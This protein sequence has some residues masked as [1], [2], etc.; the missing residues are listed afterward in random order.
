MLTILCISGNLRYCR[1]DCGL[2][3]SQNLPVAH[4][5][6]WRYVRSHFNFPTYPPHSSTNIWEPVM[7]AT[8]NSQARAA[9]LR[10]V[11][12]NVRPPVPDKSS[13]SAIYTHWRQFYPKYD[14]LRHSE[15]WPSVL[16]F[17]AAFIPA[18]SLP[19]H[20]SIR[21]IALSCSFWHDYDLY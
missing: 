17:H 7:S 5:A 21:G 10:Q 4:T 1:S 12:Q 11:L 19:S 15:R 9:R 14:T 6:F 3:T 2:F 16:T 18:R 20:P 8:P 13:L